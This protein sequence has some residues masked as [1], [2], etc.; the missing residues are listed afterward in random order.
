MFKKMQKGFTLIELMI[1]VAIIG[2]LAA[3]A[4]PGLSGLHGAREGDGRSEPGGCG[5]GRRGRGLS[6]RMTSLASR[7]RQASWLLTR[8][9]RSTYRVS[10][11]G[12]A[13]RAS[14]RSRTRM[15]PRSHGNTIMLSPFIRGRRSLHGYRSDGQHRLGVH[16]LGATPR[17]TAWVWPAPLSVACR[18]ATRRRSASNRL[19]FATKHRWKPL[20]G[21]ASFL[22]ALRASLDS[23]AVRFAIRVTSRHGDNVRPFRT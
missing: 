5:E 22:S 23:G 9:S 18:P 4:I 11:S 10:P 17:R 6:S 16:V 1:V 21:G 15:W 13:Y 19:S 20:F 7:R 2:I 14:S 3:I 8:S 12:A